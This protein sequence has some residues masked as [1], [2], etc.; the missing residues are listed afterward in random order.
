MLRNFYALEYR[1]LARVADTFVEDEAAN[2]KPIEK[3]V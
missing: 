3:Q 1:A 2:Q